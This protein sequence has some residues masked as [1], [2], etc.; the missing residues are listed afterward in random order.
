MAAN[1]QDKQNRRQLELIQPGAQYLPDDDT[2]KPPELDPLSSAQ[3][4]RAWRQNN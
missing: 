4:R 3:S 2:P 1:I